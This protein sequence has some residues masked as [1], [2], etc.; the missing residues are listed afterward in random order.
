MDYG[1]WEK[2]CSRMKPWDLTWETKRIDLILTQMERFRRTR[3]RGSETQLGRNQDSVLAITFEV[4]FR[5]LGGNVAK[6]VGGALVR[7]QICT[8]CTY[9]IHE[10][11]HHHLEQS[12]STGTML[13]LRECAGNSWGQFQLSSWLEVL[14]IFNRW[15][16]KEPICPLMNVMKEWHKE[17]SH[18]PHNFHIIHRHLHGWNTLLLSEPRASLHFT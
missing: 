3:F 9:G 17:L 18:I 7:T 16:D 13:F 14:L 5:H 4:P 6:A 10:N 2:K 1:T 12:L 8:L 15:E 11:G